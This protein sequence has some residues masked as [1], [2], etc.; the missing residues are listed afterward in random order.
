[1]RHL[2]TSPCGAVVTGVTG[3]TV[4]A[5]RVVL[6]E[7]AAKPGHRLTLWAFVED[8]GNEY[9]LL[10][11]VACDEEGVYEG[12]HCRVTLLPRGAWA[13][14]MGASSGRKVVKFLEKRLGGRQ[15]DERVALVRELQAAH[16]SL[17]IGD[18]LRAYRKVLARNKVERTDVL[19]LNRS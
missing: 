4:E 11:D 1:M 16:P 8:H 12:L 13:V 7:V 3:V 14:T 9:C 10:R 5:G 2:Q 6:N 19:K 17:K 15:H 18:I